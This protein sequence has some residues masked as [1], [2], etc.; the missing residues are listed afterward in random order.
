MQRSAP[1]QLFAIDDYLTEVIVAEDSALIGQPFEEISSLGESSI[2][3]VGLA[4]R[5][6]PVSSLR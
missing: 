2:D 1:E 3:V 5:H 6:G 4:H